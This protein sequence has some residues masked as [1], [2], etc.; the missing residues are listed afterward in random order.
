MEEKYL[1]TYTEKF[2]CRFFRKQKDQ[3]LNQLTED[4]SA[5]GYESD[6]LVSK[7]LFGQ[8]KNLVF[9]N[10]KQAKMILAVPYDTQMKIFSK[11]YKFY[12][13]DL[14]KSQQKA[15]APTFFP[16]IAIYAIALIILEIIGKFAYGTPFYPIY[17]V[18]M[19]VIFALLLFFAYFG[20]P[21]KHNTNMYSASIVSAIS[22]ASKLT[23]EQRRI[24]AFVFTDNN[25][26]TRK[27]DKLLE[28]NLIAYGRTP[29]VLTL[30]TI[31]TGDE[32]VI[33]YLNNNRKAANNFVKC[34]D[35][36]KKVSSTQIT[37]QDMEGLPIR[38]YS[39]SLMVACGTRDENNQLIVKDVQTS[40][41]TNVDETLLDSVEN[42]IL[43][44]MKRSF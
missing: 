43:E 34:F 13:L 20:F 23:K 26:R 30:S 41:D 37:E 15:F 29:Q 21:N 28:N 42:G 22:I 1:K 27:G 17:A 5:L 39:K 11:K 35:T 33:G 4:F 2:A 10:L 36:D 16:L 8:T 6:M 14:V 24:V 31:G 7:K 25:S 9:G 40:K 12:P 38:I 3:C 32:I 18:C 19:I 44:Y